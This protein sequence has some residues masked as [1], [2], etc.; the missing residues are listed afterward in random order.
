M[1]PLHGNKSR[2]NYNRNINKKIIKCEFACS[3]CISSADTNGR[4][5][6]GKLAKLLGVS[7]RERSGEQ[8]V[9]EEHFQIN[10]QCQ[11]SG[12]Y[13]VDKTGMALGLT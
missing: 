4:L 3:P 6:F 2:W 5:C 13:S 8:H 1:A 11:R 12:H 10:S 7:E 9:R